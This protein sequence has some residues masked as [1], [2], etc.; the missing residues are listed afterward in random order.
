MSDNIL[1]IKNLTKIFSNDLLKRKQSAITDLTCH[2]PQ[3]KCTGLLGHNA[4]GKTST[5][6]GILGLLKPSQG[7]I[8]FKGKPLD[9]KMRRYIGYMPETNKLAGN[10]SPAEV[11]K[12]HM[13]IFRP[14]KIS[15]NQYKDICNAKLKEVG[16]WDHRNKLISKL[17]KGMGRRLAWA[18][19]TIHS[20]ELI[21]LD[22]P[23]SGLDPLGR[24]HMA[25]WIKEIKNSGASIILC[26]H[27]LWA[28]FNLCD[29]YHILKNSKLVYST[30][31]PYH[32]QDDHEPVETEF[33][34]E[35]S[36]TS[37]SEIQKLLEL[38]RLPSWRKYLTEGYLQK[39]FFDDWTE[40]KKWLQI[41]TETDIMVVGFHQS[42]QQEEDRILTFFDGGLH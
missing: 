42:R 20:P 30:I 23:F 41:I 28:L 25:T 33:I 1:E 31:D 14:P 34:L 9:Q 7:E 38:H 35:L 10:L 15:S 26:T 24:Q 37:S 5:I 29:E 27:E 22:E 2:F 6:R 36:G 39:L 19:A 3:G 8:L 12:S 40:T 21:I 16:L 11:L 32:G 4:A 13:S 18:Q 17:S